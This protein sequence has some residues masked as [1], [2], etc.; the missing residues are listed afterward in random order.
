MSEWAGGA[1][2]QVTKE[3]ENILHLVRVAIPGVIESFDSETQTVNVQPAI[4]ETLYDLQGAQTGVALPVLPDVPLVMPRAGDYA[5][6]LPVRAGDECLVV[7]A[8][9]CIDAWWQSGGVQEQVE[10][11]R[12]DLS[13][14]F[15][16]L[17][18]WSQPRRVSCLETDK[19][20]LV[21]T[22]TGAGVEIGA[23]GIKVTGTSIMLTGSV[24]VAGSLTVNGKAVEPV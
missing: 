1:L 13:D 8:D 9:M 3:R 22:A 5:L 14:A 19:A 16:I 12:H 24:S 6:L 15:A 11:R 20:R 2:D 23:A 7:F 21:N 10:L 4:K 17:G 18:V